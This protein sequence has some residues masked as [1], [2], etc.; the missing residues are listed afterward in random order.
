MSELK[1]ITE[2]ILE[3]R[4]KRNWK[5][6]HNPKD[7]AIN[8]NIES[9]ELLELFL[10]KNGEEIKNDVNIE[11]VKDELA[12]ILHSAFLLLEHYGFDIKEIILNKLAKTELKYPVEKSMGSNKKYDEL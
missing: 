1:E 2:K 12:D 9:S 6:F 5:Q 4:D 10:W 7:L 8:L 11:N 3:F